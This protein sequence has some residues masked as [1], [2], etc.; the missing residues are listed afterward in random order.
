MREIKFRVWDKVDNTMYYQLKGSPCFG[1][2]EG[3]RAVS[4]EDVFFYESQDFDVMQYTGLTDKNGRDIYEGDIVNVNRFGGT[5]Q[6]ETVKFYT[7]GG[8]AGIHPFTDSGHHWSS[9]QC[10]VVGNIY[11][12][13]SADE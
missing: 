1:Q 6:H 3:D 13:V 9:H 2:F 12:G 8:F 7:N 4:I 10:K 11:E 5:P